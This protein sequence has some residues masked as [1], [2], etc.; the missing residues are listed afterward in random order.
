MPKAKPALK[1]GAAAKGKKGAAPQKKKE[2]TKNPL[3]ASR[4]RNFTVGVDFDNRKRDVTRFVLWPR[5]IVRQRQKRVLERRLK[6]PPSLNQFRM[7]LDNQTKAE[8]FKLMSKYKPETQKERAE[9]LAA[10]AE[11]KKADPKAQPAKRKAS[12]K[13]GIQEVTRMVEEKRAKLVV[14]AHDV[15]PIE[16]VLWLPALCK[17][18]GVPYCIVK[19][20]AALGRF[21]GMKTCT[22]VALD[23]VKG[24]DSASFGKI[25]DAVQSGFSGRYEDLKKKWGGLQMGRRS[26]AKAAKHRKK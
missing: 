16:I 20:K 26:I 9:R 13:Y 6:V 11:K 2:E 25:E 8:L 22:C 15:D 19:G 12:L 10:E 23:S 21:V 3:F 7:T 24:E 5:Y 18:Q 17:A 1:K 4:P 14:I